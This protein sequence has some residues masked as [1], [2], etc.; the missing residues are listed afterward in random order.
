MHASAPCKIGYV[1][2]L[3]WPAARLSGSCGGGM[4]LFAVAF[5]LQRGEQS[6]M[7]H[8]WPGAA[9]VQL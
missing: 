3:V 5:F 8:P 6:M 1:A 9:G 7:S 4:L 2:A